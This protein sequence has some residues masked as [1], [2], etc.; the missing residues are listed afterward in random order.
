MNQEAIFSII[1]SLKVLTVDLLI[2]IIIGSIISF[3]LA[4]SNSIYAKFISLILDLPLALSPIV[5]GFLLLYFLSENS[6]LGKILSKININ[7]IF[8]FYSLVLAGFIASLPWYSNLVFK[9]YNFSHKKLSYKCKRSCLYKRQ[10]QIKHFYIYNISRNKKNIF[11]I[12][13]FINN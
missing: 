4:E 12:N 13:H 7:L 8:N 9:T 6:Y 5:T 3:Y 2:L 10:K 11:G 1:L